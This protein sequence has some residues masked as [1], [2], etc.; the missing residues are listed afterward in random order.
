MLTT[1]VNV[2]MT[3]GAS[4]FYTK[5]PV[6]WEAQEVR[7]Y[8]LFVNDMIARLSSKTDTSVRRFRSLI[9]RCMEEPTQSRPLFQDIVQE[10][11]VLRSNMR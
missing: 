1:I 2:G 5:G 10:L 9:T 4:F 3:A 7:A 6:P 11:D 8:G